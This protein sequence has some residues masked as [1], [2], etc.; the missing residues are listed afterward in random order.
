MQVVELGQV[1]RAADTEGLSAFYVHAQRGAK[2]GDAR[3]LAEAFVKAG[4]SKVSNG[5]FTRLL[6]RFLRALEDPA[7]Q[8]QASL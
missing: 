6:G 7:C 2:F 4:D 8:G 5:N 3:A 1:G